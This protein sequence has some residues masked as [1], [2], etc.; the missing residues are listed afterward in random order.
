MPDV[1]FAGVTGDA[2][3][4]KRASENTL[5]TEAHNAVR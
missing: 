3:A 1:D 2:R 4:R 5:S